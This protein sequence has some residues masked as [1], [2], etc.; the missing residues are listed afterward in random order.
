MNDY[1][2]KIRR[3]LCSNSAIE[4]QQL[5]EH[6]ILLYYKLMKQKR[7]INVFIIA[8]VVDSRLQQVKM[9]PTF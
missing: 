6:A 9:A 8:A 2:K 3:L 4:V 7:T 1:F 5:I